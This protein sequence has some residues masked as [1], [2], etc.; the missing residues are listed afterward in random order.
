MIDDRR[1]YEHDGIYA[2]TCIERAILIFKKR[3]RVGADNAERRCHSFSHS[4]IHLISIQ[5]F[6]NSNLGSPSSFHLFGF[7]FINTCSS[8]HQHSSERER[9]IRPPV[10]F[11][12]GPASGGAEDPRVRRVAGGEDGGAAEEMS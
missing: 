2:R 5:T 3:V 11:P 7:H 12:A 8:S 6:L 1:V 10:A 4:F 9:L